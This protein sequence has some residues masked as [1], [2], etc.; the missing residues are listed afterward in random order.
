MKAKQCYVIL[1]FFLFA[2]TSCSRYKFRISEEMEN[3][4][5]KITKVQIYCIDRGRL[6]FDMHGTTPLYSEEYIRQYGD[7]FVFYKGGFSKQCDIIALLL[8]NAK[9]VNINPQKNIVQKKFIAGQL[10]NKD[11]GCVI[12]IHGKS[13]NAEETKKTYIMQNGLNV[14]YEKG[15]EGIYYEMPKILLKKYN[16]NIPEFN[17]EYRKLFKHRNRLAE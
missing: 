9:P 2:L 3:Y 12:D 15:K 10:W 8:Y 14:F 1:V 11:G 13:G 7:L 6:F 16:I 5:N 17:S 4:L